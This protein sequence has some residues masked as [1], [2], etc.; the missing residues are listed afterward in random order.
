MVE[1]VVQWRLESYY[2]HIN[3]YSWNVKHSYYLLQKDLFL[4]KK[5]R[6]I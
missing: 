1:Y 2:M 3:M 5:H 4:N 6:N